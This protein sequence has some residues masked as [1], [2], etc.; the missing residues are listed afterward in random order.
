MVA[1]YTR[2]SSAEQAEN[3]YSIDE[4]ERIL[5]KYCRDHAIQSTN[6]ILTRGFQE[7]TS[8]DAQP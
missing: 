4:Q 3:G 5:E 2:V 7:K 8:K 1:I 6:V